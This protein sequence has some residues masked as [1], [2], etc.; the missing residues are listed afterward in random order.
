VRRKGDGVHFLSY[1]ELFMQIVASLVSRLIDN[2]NDNAK[3]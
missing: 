2:D 1:L 3:E